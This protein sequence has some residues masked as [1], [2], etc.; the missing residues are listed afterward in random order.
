[1]TAGAPI[2]VLR[3]GKPVMTV[4][5]PG[6]RRVISSILHTIINVLDHRMGAQDAVSTVRVHSE[7][8]TTV[9]DAR[10]APET[11]AA[12]RDMGHRLDVREETFSTTYFGRPN[13][14]VVDPETGRLQGG[15]NAL[16]P[17]L[18]IGL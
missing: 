5:S 2:I 16:K 15:V 10:L 3:D 14:V 6:G 9:V 18:A 13:T 1:L 4:G 11:L 8:E 17:A 12:L 7:D